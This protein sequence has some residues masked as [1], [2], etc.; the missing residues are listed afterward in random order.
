MTKVRVNAFSV[1]LDGYGA[2][3]NQTREEPL[4]L[5]GEE[6]H[7]WV[8]TTADWAKSHGGQGGT[9]GAD[10]DFAARAM[11][12]L[13]A[14]IMGRNMF[15][16]VR[17]P[18]PDYEWKGWWGKNPPYH[19]P[20]FVLTRHERPQLEME[21]GT[22]FHFVTGGIHEAMERARE[23]AGDKD[24]RIGGGVST[25]NQYLRERMIDELHIAVAP[26]FLGGGER[27]Y[28][29]VDMRALGYQC[30]RM[31]ST[32]KATHMLITRQDT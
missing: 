7:E 27:L 3:P 18:W 13:G 1:S 20:V 16:P 5:G 25:V 26:V 6:L 2:G 31:V 15:G 19:C 8:V 17:G 29:D 21:G 28:D 4:G 10:N 11:S 12:N 32:E 24:I 30:T 14:W 23:A 22:I 9:T